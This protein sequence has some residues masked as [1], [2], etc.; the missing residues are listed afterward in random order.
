MN[1]FKTIAVI[2][3][4]VS[5]VLVFAFITLKKTQ[6]GQPP[7]LI[8]LS[9]RPPKEAVVYLSRYC[10]VG[11]GCSK[12]DLKIVDLNSKE[13]TILQSFDTETEVG[14][15]VSPD[16]T[17]VAVAPRGRNGFYYYDVSKHLGNY[18]G[19][20]LGDLPYLYDCVWS[21]DND[22]LYC[23]TR[24]SNRQAVFSFLGLNKEVK[25]VFE[26][27]IGEK[28]LMNISLLHASR[29]QLIYRIKKVES[30]EMVAYNQGAKQLVPLFQKN[31][32]FVPVTKTANNK[33]F[34]YSTEDGTLTKVDLEKKESSQI[35]KSDRPFSFLPTADGSSVYIFILG[36]EIESS[37][38]EISIISKDGQKNLGE[39]NQDMSTV[40]NITSENKIVFSKNVPG[41]QGESQI[42]LYDP[43]K[44]SLEI[45]ADDLKWG[46]NF[47]AGLVILD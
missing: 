36:K 10:T 35:Y 17:V 11:Q 32:T 26:T 25:K 45:L 7:S 22:G 3:L 16:K 43:S 1:S 30:F 39:L 47:D 8:N 18:L 29:N 21:E 38:T 4:I 27:K 19:S 40:I 20:P 46:T 28:E 33:I 6:T 34:W 2:T 44:N 13:K 9:E 31:Q 14:L 15:L 41:T 23:G 42:W 37:P 24:S 5:G 12:S